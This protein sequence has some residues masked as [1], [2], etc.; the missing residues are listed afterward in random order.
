MKYHPSQSA[1]MKEVRYTLREAMA[2]QGITYAKLVDTLKKS[3]Q[4]LSRYVTVYERDGKVGDSAAQAEFDRIMA[5]QELRMMHLSSDRSMEEIEKAKEKN[6]AEERIFRRDYESFLRKILKNHPDLRLLDWNDEPVTF[7][8]L[9]LDRAWGNRPVEELDDILTEGEIREWDDL[10]ERYGGIVL[11]MFDYSRAERSHILEKLWDSTIVNGKP[12]TYTDRYECVI[13]AEEAGGTLY[14]FDSR[15][16]CQFA[17]DSARIYMKEPRVSPEVDRELDFSATV[18][19]IVE[20]DVIPVKHADMR[21]IGLGY[22]V[23]DVKGL[24]PG[25]KYLYSLNIT[26]SADDSENLN[27]M[28]YTLM[29]GY[30]STEHPLK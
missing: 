27:D 7:E 29:E 13:S 19:L 23:A 15:S 11:D 18:W 3:R 2:D 4:T 30:E 24:F 10:Y 8:N 14:D 25:Y 6:R 5:E 16:F 9:N 21:R 22:Y 1:I 12:R 26:V 17:G 20:G 28:E